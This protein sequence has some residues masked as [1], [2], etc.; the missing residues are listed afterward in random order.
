[1]WSAGSISDSKAMRLLY[2]LQG[3]GH[4]GYGGDAEPNEESLP[5]D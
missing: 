2:G 1:M 3:Y 5:L 4:F